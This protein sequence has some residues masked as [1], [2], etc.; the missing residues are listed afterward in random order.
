MKFWRISARSCRV[1]GRVVVSKPPTAMP[2]P[3][4]R[5]A[6]QTQTNRFMP[7]RWFE[8]VE[9]GLHGR[10]GRA[11]SPWMDSFGLQLA[12]TPSEFLMQSWCSEDSLRQSKTCKRNF[13]KPKGGI[14]YP[15][16][17]TFPTPLRS[18]NLHK[19]WRVPWSMATAS[20]ANH[21]HRSVP[22]PNAARR[23]WRSHG[24]PADKKSSRPVGTPVASFP[25]L[26]TT[27]SDHTEKWI[28]KSVTDSYPLKKDSNAFLF[29]DNF[30]IWN[31]GKNSLCPEIGGTQP[32]PCLKEASGFCNHK[33]FPLPRHSPR[34]TTLCFNKLEP[35]FWLRPA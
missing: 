27:N 22:H 5:I 31:L 33:G 11:L 1:W 4:L 35:S 20:G 28:T 3:W 21:F 2:K 14:C 9:L 26:G 6:T 16:V 23:F 12:N 13:H 17:A 18:L 8:G 30:R 32:P 19:P 7:S 15:H 24:S 29:S 10:V 25:N 34:I